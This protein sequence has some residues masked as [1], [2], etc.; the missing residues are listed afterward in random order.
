MINFEF[1]F[2]I[3]RIH[4]VVYN[5]IIFDGSYKKVSEKLNDFI[6]SRWATL[7]FPPIF[8]NLAQ[9]LCFPGV[10]QNLARKT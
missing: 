2:F 9:T 7:C 4:T 8:Q 10:F 3:L 1:S 6:F 5:L